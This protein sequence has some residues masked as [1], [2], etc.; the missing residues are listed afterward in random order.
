M[1]RRAMSKKKHEVME[2]E[3]KNFI[4]GIVD[5]K[6][7]IQVPGCIRNGISESIGNKIFDT[8]M[9]FAS[10]AFNKSHAAA[11]AVVAYQTAFLMRYYPVEMIAAMLNSVKDSSEK[12]AYYIKFAEEKGIQVLPPNINESYGKFT[13]KGDV[14]I[15]GIGAIKNVGMNVVDS[16][17]KARETKGKFT[18]LEDF[19]DK[20][21]TSAINKRAVESLIKAGAMD[22][23]KVFRSRMLAVFEKAMDGRTNERKRNIEGQISLFSLDENSIDIP[24]INYPNI[25]EFDKS[26]IL[27]MEKEMTG[28]YLSGHPLDEYKK[29]LSMQT[30]ATIRGIN[31]SYE[32]IQETSQSLEEGILDKEPKFKD[33]DRV[34]LGGILTSVNEKVTKNNTLMAFLQL[35]DLTGVIEVI[36]F[37][38]TLDKLRDVIEKDKLVVV[39]GRISIREDEP[40]K[41]ICES[42]SGLEKV[43]GEKIYIQIESK[44][45]IN[46]VKFNLKNCTLAK[47]GNTPIYL[48]VKQEKK[49]YRLSSEFWIESNSELIKELKESF[50]EKN[51]KIISK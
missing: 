24:K 5:E 34:V 40:P 25:E 14:I 6:G 26:T 8:M 36:V 38:K 37:S 45:N 16:I 28:L 11:Y 46:D 12:V 10:Y 21:D 15:F 42:I 35:E 44:N 17:V 19:I 3:R 29:S 1:I 47:K 30:T 51:I 23:F 2:E 9:D 43:N 20:I 32:L 33:N 13:V 7:N 50:G 31:E 22:D 18:S 27:A 4:Y 49:Y 48:Y 41:L 39:K